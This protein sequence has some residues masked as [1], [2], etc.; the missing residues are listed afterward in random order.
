MAKGKGTYLKR[1][2]G[3]EFSKICDLKSIT[4][5]SRSK[6]DVEEDECL[7]DEPCCED[8]SLKSTDYKRYAPGQ[9]EL[10]ELSVTVKFDPTCEETCKNHHYFSS[11]FDDCTATFWAICFPNGAVRMYHVYVKEESIGDIEP[12]EDMEAEFTLMPT[13]CFYGCFE[14]LEKAEEAIPDIGITAPQN[15]WVN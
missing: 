15:N 10:G 12:S 9:K 1:W 14:S 13:G 4:P 5:P 8:G 3:T 2:S 7:D 11:D 6:E